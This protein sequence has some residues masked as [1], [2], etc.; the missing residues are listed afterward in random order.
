MYGYIDPWYFLLVVPALLITG[1]AQF[2]VQSTFK[3]YSQ[4]G[5]RSGLTGADASRRIQQQNGISL[6]VEHVGGSLT[7]HY[8][9]RTNTIRLS[10]TV[11]QSQS[12]AAVGVAAHE[13]GHALQYAEQYGWIKFR[14][15]ILPVSQ[16]SSQL[17][18][19]LVMVG[20]L[21]S[22]PF[23]AYAGIAFF[24]VALLFQLVTLP[25][26][27][28]ASAR[29]IQALEQGGVMTE[30]ELKGARKVLS[31]AAL[32]YVGAV[33]VSLMS[34]LRLLIIVFGRGRRDD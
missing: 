14:M 30:E 34:L 22:I 16:F 11:Y 10:D 31:A 7:D 4:V 18:P 25:V 1:W 5:T 9:P 23:L 24:C 19:Y 3:K 2:K 17:S 29:A 20:L 33:L 28:N 6:P 32:T 27:F 15:A 12:I 13:T 8:D 26:E 21:F